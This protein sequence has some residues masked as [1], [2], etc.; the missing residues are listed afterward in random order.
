[1]SSLRIPLV[2]AGTAAATVAALCSAQLAI[3]SSSSAAP[4]TSG[5]P[6]SVIVVLRDQLRGKPATRAHVAARR[7]A[8]R[9][10]QNAVV[11]RA[12]RVTSHKAAKV[13]HYTAANVV[14]MTVNPSQ[15]SELKSDPAVSAVIPNTKVAFIPRK[16]EEPAG[17]KRSAKAIGE[18]N[19]SAVC[20]TDPSK[21]LLE[22]EALEDTHTA[23]DDADAKTAQQ[24]TTG[25]GVKVAYIADGINP[26]NPDF[27]RA[28]GD[29]VITDY[30]AFSA[31]GP[32][33]EEGGAEAYGDASAIAAQG[34]VSHD[35]STFVNP[36]YPL[37]SGCNI[38]VL[39]MAPGASIVALKIDFYTTSIIQAIDYAVSNDHV[40]VI[41]ESF[42]GNVVPDASA[43]S[44]IQSF[45]DAAIAAGA[46]VVVSSGDA[47]TTG[48][49]GNPATDPNV[50]SVAANT[51]SRGYQQTGYA[52]A[53]TFGNG[54]WVNDEVSS[55]S[56]GGVTQSG[57]TVDLTAPGESGWAVCDAGSAE[58][59]NY[60]GGSSDIQLFG[61]TSQSAPLTAGAAALVISAYRSTHSGNSP[62]P[63][64]VKQLLKGTATDLGLPTDE[65]GSGL[66]DARSAVEAALT[67]NGATTAAPAGVQS[68]I[69]TNPHLISV[70]GAPGSTHTVKVAVR[71]VGAEP[72]T[73]ATGSR[74][75]RTDSVATINT[76]IDASSPQTFPYPTN[77]TSWVYKKVPF[78][79]PSGEDRLAAKMI[80]QGA[81]KQ[82]GSATV[83]PVVRI[84]LFD[85]S[86]TY[87]ANSR[88]QGGA[89]SANYANLDVRRPTAGNWTAVI[90]T[91]GSASG[92]TGDVNLRL[93]HQS[94]ID[95]AKV[96]TPSMTLA[97]GQYRNVEA[98][99][100]T[101]NNGD[102]A[103]ALTVATSNGHRTAIPVILRAVIPTSSGKG[104]FNGTIT[105]GNA[106]AGSAAQSLTYA[107]DVPSGR[108][109]VS[110][111]VTL[112]SDPNYE[113]EGVLVDP[114]D[115]TQ[116]I[117]SNVYTGA[118]GNIAGRGLSMQLT[119]ANPVAGRW[120]LVILVVNPVPGTAISQPF[121]GTIAFDANNVSAT[122]LP[123]ST[124]TVLPAGKAT[125]AKVTV[126]NTGKAPINVQVDPRTKSVGAMQ[127]TS[128][129][130]TQNVQLPSHNSP[131]FIV[132]PGT[133]GLTAVS[134][135]DV[136]A[137]VDLL[138]GSQGIDV[139]GDL[140]A[141]KA[142]S[143]ISTATVDEGANATVSSGIWYTDLNEIGAVDEDGAPSGDAHVQLTAR[144]QD[145]DRTVTSS[146]GDF[147]NVATDSTASTGAPVTIAPGASATITVT[148]KPTATKGTKV[149]G[150]L[151]VYTPP[152]FAYPT[153][154]TTG[155]TLR[156]LDYS[157]TVG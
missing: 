63:A 70:S 16:Q 8:A 88:P 87:V 26:D 127:L 126:R 69:V 138:S 143:T 106:R 42:G 73:V 97:A 114:N 67:Y 141:A 71:N 98:T 4:A 2:A 45:N 123:T 82:V 125:T 1:M 107:F 142:G 80:W 21:P 12:N 52:G 151:Y 25:S 128:P 86:G 19:S 84:S 144:T 122:G 81:P 23:S 5:K 6:Q 111:G 124:K 83:T 140:P 10:A 33:P 139:V 27:I 79:V 35:L 72:L 47:G 64:L 17:A 148:I 9:S 153:F 136:P 68:Q 146:T 93:Y 44:A 43:R 95:V 131:T 55:L 24:L 134:T 115:E 101:P 18:P 58:C 65:Q 51:N 48:T 99:F 34:L 77:G 31:D 54:Q 14:S 103:Y 85:P 28:N 59:A 29:H 49:I 50:I 89:V 155:D 57:G 11:D 20:P 129:F 41:N 154:N 15:V 133:H 156:T 117:G 22:P 38:R 105:G 32:A 56:S 149:S 157:Y 100:T 76:S 110:V 135:S 112:R 147:W 116:S 37:P 46:T 94:A 132:P 121:S 150:Q 75:Y 66:L 120:R 104:S 60:R 152:S 36:A 109:D 96:A 62:S 3:A 118:D 113:L 13:V 119:S 53:R 7:A 108:K 39:G 74:R 137:I 61:G 30:K 78:T 90:Y 102:T 91:A 92:Y 130:G 40:D 145:F